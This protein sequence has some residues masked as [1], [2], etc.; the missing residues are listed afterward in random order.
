[1][2]RE[3]MA[4]LLQFPILPIFFLLLLL[5]QPGKKRPGSQ[6]YLQKFHTKDIALLRPGPFNFTLV[7]SFPGIPTLHLGIFLKTFL[8]N[9]KLKVKE[10]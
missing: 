1:M 2:S 10:V 4:I 8:K 9:W 5:S 6:S 7:T 3:A